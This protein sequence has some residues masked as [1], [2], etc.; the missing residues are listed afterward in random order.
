[1]RC[2]HTDTTDC[3][4]GPAAT[5]RIFALAW[6]ARLELSGGSI[7]AGKNSELNAGFPAQCVEGVEES[8]AFG[9]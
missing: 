1:M 2:A 3:A 9:V 5:R 6:L 4:I 8:L 7:P